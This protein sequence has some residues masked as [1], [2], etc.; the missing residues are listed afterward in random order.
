VPNRR[1]PDV[2]QIVK[3]FESQLRERMDG[4]MSARTPTG[5]RET[6]LEIAAAARGLADEVT[7]KILVTMA[8][9]GQW[10]EEVVSAARTHGPYRGGGHRPV[11]VTLLGGKSVTLRVKYLKPDRRGLQGRPRGVG[12]RG[13]GGAGLYPVLAALGIWFAVSP[14]AAAEICRQVAD[15]DSVRAGREA[16][17]RRGLDL[18]HKQTLRIVNHVGQR[19]VAQRSAW[20]EKAL[21]GPAVD[22]FLAGK[23]V[24]IATDGGRLRERVPTRGRRREATGHRRYDTPWREPKVIVIYV[25]DENGRPVAEYRPIYDGTLGDC[26]ETFQMLQAYLKQ[27]GAHLAKEL[28]VVGDGAKWIWGRVQE[29]AASVGVH[30]DRVVEVIDWYHAIETLH[31]IAGARSWDDASKRRW[32]KRAKRLLFR[33]DTEGLLGE[34]D[35]LARGRNARAISKH[36]DYFARNGERMQ[37]RTF[38]SNGVPLGS[39]AV[40]SAVRRI[41]NMRM[42]ANGTF[43]LEVN[44]EGILPLRSFL[45]SGRFDDLID[46]S[47]HQAAPWSSTSSNTPELLA[48]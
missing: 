4:W 45:K 43:W 18:G 21:D 17:N 9:D 14:A 27:A 25:I 38:K 1:T 47:L 8:D 16:L 42:K 31:E 15:S 11:T 24:V 44:A 46:W 12:R 37:Y 20:I 5:F 39:G 26:D 13:K 30:P 23:R 33:G 10:A 3:D 34:I 41:V 6:E 19:I 32:M 36:R 22:G 2:S 35:Q 28:I 29:L 48:A 40:E 7:A